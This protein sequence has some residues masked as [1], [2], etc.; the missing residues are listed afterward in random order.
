MNRRCRQCDTPADIG[1][2]TTLE[3][4]EPEGASRSAGDAAPAGAGPPAQWRHLLILLPVGQLTRWAMHKFKRFRGKYAK[5]MA[6]LQKVY[7]HQPGLFAHWQL[8]AFTSGRT[9]G[10]R[11]TGDRHVRS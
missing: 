1:Q 5:A 4:D 11:M 10:G 3:D 8:A 6:W 9:V 7:Q 2:R